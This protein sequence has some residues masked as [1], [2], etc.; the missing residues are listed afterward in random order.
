MK[1]NIQA[2]KKP[3]TITVPNRQLAKSITEETIM[4]NDIRNSLE[5]L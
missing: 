1:I 5:M 2:T 3:K 4:N